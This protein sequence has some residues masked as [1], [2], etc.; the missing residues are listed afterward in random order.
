[1]DFLNFEQVISI[2]Y[3]VITTCVPPYTMFEMGASKNF[4]FPWTK[5]K[6]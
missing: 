2:R 4:K 3:V 5:K 1:M 6:Q